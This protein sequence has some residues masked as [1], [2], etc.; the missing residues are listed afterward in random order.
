MPTYTF[1]CSDCTQ[2]WDRNVP[3]AQRNSQECPSCGSAQV[4]RPIT[5]TQVVIPVEHRATGGT[6]TRR[7]STL[8]NV[9]TSTLPVVGRDG[10]LYSAD[11]KKVIQG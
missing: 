9:D 2:L 3:S 11:G 8:G 1:R 5:G 6:R 10:K 4:T 7:S